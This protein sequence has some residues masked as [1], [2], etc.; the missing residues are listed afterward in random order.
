MRENAILR[1]EREQAKKVLQQQHHQKNLIHSAITSV[2]ASLHEDFEA[3]KEHKPE[4]YYQ[5]QLHRHKLRNHK[6]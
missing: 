3:G 1:E 4:L 2:K 5:Q 6:R